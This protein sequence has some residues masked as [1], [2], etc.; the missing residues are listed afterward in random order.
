MYIFVMS[1]I[2]AKLR[3]VAITLFGTCQTI[4]L[5]RTVGSE[6]PRS[7]SKEMLRSL[8]KEA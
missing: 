6:T 5:S 7:R 3:H 1:M 2:N 4:D 8:A